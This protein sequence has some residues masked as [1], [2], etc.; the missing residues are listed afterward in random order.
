MS[1]R[2]SAESRLASLLMWHAAWRLRRRY[3]EWVEAMASE[4]RTLACE[5]ERSRWSAGCAIASYGAPGAFDWAIY[6][7]ALTGGILLMAA[8][9]WR[10]D[11]SLRTVAVL[12]AIGFTLG[13]LQPGC[14]MVSGAAVGLVVAAV[15]G[16]ETISGVRPAY[17]ATTHSLMHDAR[18][19]LLVAPALLASLVGGDARGRLRSDWRRSA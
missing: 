15:N 11:E 17:E 10:A 6:P 13:L 5:Q 2:A 18:W 8:Y 14:A 4:G 3:P 19:T 1:L 9:Q 12:A 7:A 16:F